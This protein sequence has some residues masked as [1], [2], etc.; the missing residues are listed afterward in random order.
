MNNDTEIS[1]QS[2]TSS[3]SCCFTL[4]AAAAAL[5]VVVLVQGG[6]CYEVNKRRCFS[7]IVELYREWRSSVQCHWLRHIHC[8][9]QLS[10]TCLVGCWTQCCVRYYKTSATDKTTA[11]RWDHRQL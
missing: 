6:V 4:S 11:T 9:Q 5:V 3:S 2:E 1:A 10:A 7:Y 8:S